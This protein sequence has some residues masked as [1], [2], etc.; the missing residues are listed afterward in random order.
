M[1]D[2]IGAFYRLLIEIVVGANTT[3]ENRR[4]TLERLCLGED[5]V[6][7]FEEVLLAREHE[8]QQVD[9]PQIWGELTAAFQRGTWF[10]MDAKEHKARI[11]NGLLLGIPLADLLF[12]MGLGRVLRRTIDRLQSAGVLPEIPQRSG[13]I[14]QFPDDV[15]IEAAALGSATLFRDEGIFLEGETPQDLIC[16]V[17]LATTVMEEELKGVGLCMNFA[18]NKTECIMYQVGEGSEQIWQEG[19]VSED[20][21]VIPIREGLKLRVAQAYKLVGTVTDGLGGFESR[22]GS[23]SQCQG[24]HQAREKSV[25]STRLMVQRACCTPRLVSSGGAREALMATADESPGIAAV[26]GATDNRRRVRTGTRW[27]L[28]ATRKSDGEPAKAQSSFS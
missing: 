4:S 3:A 2:A 11:V 19:H 13:C 12:N 21:T 5:D 15:A 17:V 20:A 1:T 25:V 6:K 27:G 18:A 24:V 9:P 8:L 26:R 16:R 10:E 22:G 14:F 28:F 23:A 7:A